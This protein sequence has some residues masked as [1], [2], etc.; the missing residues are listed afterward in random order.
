MKRI[1][2]VYGGSSTESEI[3]ILTAL[4]TYKE[5]MKTNK[6]ITLVYLD[7]EGN[8]YIGKELLN[9][10]SYSLKKN[11]IKVTFNKKKGKSYYSYHLKKKY[12]DFALILGH[13]KN[14]EDGTLSSY[15]EVLKIP[16][17]YDD[18]S[19]VSLLQDKVKTKMVFNSLNITQTKFKYIHKY[20]YDNFSFD[21]L[22]LNYPLICKPSR[23]G[24]SIGI[25]KC[26]N[27]QELKEGL[28]KGFMYDETM[29]IEEFIDSKIEYNIALLGYENKIIV[30]DI[31]Q[32]N[33][34]DQV[35]SFYDK[36][37]YSKSNE[38][39]VIKPKV[40]SLIKEEMI[41]ISKLVFN[42][43]NLC[44]L[45]RFDFIFDTK[46]EKLYLNELNTLPGSLAYYLFESKGIRMVDLILMYIDVLTLK[47]K[48][49]IHLIDTFQEGF[50]SKVDL[51]K[52]KK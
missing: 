34:N 39:R 37:D 46:N 47:N 15:F 3:S 42:E 18:L 7:H 17:L 40:S 8:F 32:V 33:Q 45:Y 26:N 6:N 12:F 1:V 51:D 25:K 52:L 38:K 4:K 20:Q 9:L 44:G 10:E 22:N 31:E 28:L 27:F 23:L 13:G 14:V 43:L 50:V 41:N 24:S 19:N 35:L 5:L 30:S 16:Y 21:S 48:N 49:R 36:Y 29:L 2:L 11:F